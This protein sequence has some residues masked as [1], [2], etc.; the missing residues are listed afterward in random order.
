MSYIY[1]GADVVE[2]EDVMA[3]DVGPVG[4]IEFQAAGTSQPTFQW[5]IQPVPWIRKN[6]FNAR[7][8]SGKQ[9]GAID[10]GKAGDQVRATALGRVT[11]ARDTR[12]ARGKA[13]NLDLGSGWEVRHYHL[14]QIYVSVGDQVTVG[15][16][17]GVVGRTGLPVNGV[18]HLHFEVRRNGKF[19]DPSDALEQA[20]A[21]ASGGGGLLT[22][23]AIATGVVAVLK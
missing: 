1:L 14:D 21:S 13:V 7:Y 6:S 5:P 12:D 8:P 2:E 16:P 18:A 4:P 19:F 10:M 3:E 22:A 11:L 17:L 15:T 23:V 20:K 9:H